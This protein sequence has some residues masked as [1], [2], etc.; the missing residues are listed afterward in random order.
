MTSSP[1]TVH[2]ALAI[3]NYF[4]DRGAE[5]GIPIDQL[6]LQKL[7]YFAQAWHLAVTGQPL[8]FQTV[9]AW[10]HGP[11]I[12]DVYHEFKK[13]GRNAIDG[14]ATY[15]EL[16]DTGE[17]TPIAATFPEQTEQVLRRVWDVYHNYSGVELSSMA[18]LEGTPWDQMVG[19]LK[20]EQRRD[21]P[22]P[23]RLMREYYSRLAESRAGSSR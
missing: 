10:P 15:R 12:R 22:I 4:L 13:Y 3:A 16:T 17:R 6:K 14:R 7:V 19:Q 8:F 21:I 1:P 18:H 20:P 5:D 2:D 11:V 9:L 23:N